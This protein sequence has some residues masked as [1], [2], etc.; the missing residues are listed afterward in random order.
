MCKIS[1]EYLLPISRYVIENTLSVV[2]IEGVALSCHWR[3]L[4][5]GCIIGLLCPFCLHIVFAWYKELN[6]A[7]ASVHVV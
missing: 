3:F 6:G 2:M 4:V 1:I 7:P 5:A